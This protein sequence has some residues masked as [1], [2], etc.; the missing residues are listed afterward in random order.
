MERQI[1]DTDIYCLLKHIPYESV[2]QRLKDIFGEDMIF[3]KRKQLMGYLVWKFDGEGW[4][5]LYNAEP[6]MYRLVSDEFDRQKQNILQKFTDD[7]KSLSEQIMSVPDDSCIYY[8]SDDNGNIKIKIAAWGYIFQTI[9]PPSPKPP[10]QN[11]TLKIVY[12]G[13]PCA[14]KHFHILATDGNYYPLTTDG[15]GCKSFSYT[16]GGTV[17][18]KI[19]GGEYS[20]PLEDDTSEYIVDTTLKTKVTV[21]VYT[22]SYPESGAKVSAG[23]NEYFTEADGIATFDVPL[24]QNGEEF[25]VSVKD[26]TQSQSLKYGENNFF[27]EFFTPKIAKVVVKVFTDGLPEADVT[28]LTSLQTDYKTD[29]NGIAE[30][31][32]PLPDDNSQLEVIVKGEKKSKV[33][34]EGENIF[35]FYFDKP[36]SGLSG[37]DNG[38]DTANGGVSVG[39]SVFGF[40]TATV[41]ANV[42]YYDGKPIVNERVEVG[43]NEYF[44][45]ENGVCRIEELP[46]LSTEYYVRVKDK[47]ESRILNEGENVFD[48]KFEAITPP[49]PPP[50]PPTSAFKKFLMFLGILLLVAATYYTCCQILK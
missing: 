17:R 9:A 43:N 29:S 16:K 5:S 22:D 41:V 44:T 15:N 39:G 7:I 21:K 18:L 19:N 37:S 50:P 45:D 14:N 26:Q 48:F 36:I 4:Q 3:A 30:F 34:A 23:G 24:P 20:V 31:D 38:G 6:V 13:Q 35:E 32:I 25:S 28:I 1:K 49:L 11:I 8:K 47:V 10:L 12:N 33:L 40:K 2:Y 42:S 46:L 27:Y